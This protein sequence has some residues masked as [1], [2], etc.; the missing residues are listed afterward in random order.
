MSTKAFKTLPL[1]RSRVGRLKGKFSFPLPHLI[2]FNFPPHPYLIYP[3]PP[4][5]LFYSELGRSANL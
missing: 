2:S 5:I 3:P 4:P 1:I